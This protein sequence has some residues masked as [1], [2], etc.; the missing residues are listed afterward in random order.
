MNGQKS[1]HIVAF[2]LETTGIDLKKDH[3]IQIAMIKFDIDTYNTIDT[4]ES[5]I[6]PIGNYFISPAAFFKHKIKPDFLFDKP[7]IRD[8]G[9]QIIDFF[10]DCDV[11][12]YNGN[13]FDIPFLS[14]ELNSVGLH[15]D[16]V[17][18][19]C[20]DSFLEEKRRYPSN[21][22][23]IY[24][25]YVGESMEASGLKAHDA[26]SDIKA[27]IEIYK[28]QLNEAPIVP[29]KIYGISGFIKDAEFNNVEQPCFAFGKYRGIGVELI[30]KVDNDYIK[31]CV[32]S[33]SDFDN[34]TK[35]FL[36]KYL[37]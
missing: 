25:K 13:K 6:K 33:K 20:Y 31:W 19:L 32:S 17:N 14:Q 28:N 21:L 4:F 24:E 18:R 36:E 29:D 23:A 12:S 2:D 16:F 11:L 15:I 26:F 8:I 1:K 3:I 10:G 9:Q 27:T 35:K 37:K 34:D 5:Y 7:T 30:A 22:D